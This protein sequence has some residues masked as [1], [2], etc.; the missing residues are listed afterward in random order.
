MTIAAV[1]ASHTPLK[2]YLSPGSDVELE[3]AH[4]FDDIRAWIGGFAP[5][6]LVILGPDHFNG[7]FYRLM[8]S[9]CIG[10]AAQGVG[11]WKTSQ[12]PF[13]IDAAFAENCTRHLHQAGI[14]AALSYQ[15]A[16]DHGCVQIIDQLFDWSALP[17]ILP[18]FINCAAPP[19]PPLHRTVA[20]GRA[21]GEFLGTLKRRVLVIGSGGLSHDPPIPQL[22]DASPEV[23]QRLIEGGDLTIE[24]RAARQ[25]R[26]IEDAHNRRA[27]KSKRTP[28]NPAWDKRFL[29]LLM[30]GDFTQLCTLD[31]AGITKEGG[32]GGHEIRTWIAASAAIETTGSFSPKLHYYRAIEDWIAGYAVMSFDPIET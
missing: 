30:A 25:A 21:L 6:L 9:F 5:E 23:R 15:M 16:A 18:I 27:G 24:Q 2:D 8:P 1:C 29:E 20:F 12:K 14:D 32:C 10:A 31:D 22:T 17:P 11:D 28:L 19:L 3:V 26:V 7:F 4:C 13:P